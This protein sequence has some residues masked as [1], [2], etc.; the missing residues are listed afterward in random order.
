[1]RLIIRLL[2]LGSLLWVVPV[3]AGVTRWVSTTGSDSNTCVQAQ[4]QATA[5]LT[6]SAGITCMTPSNGD[7]LIITAGTYT[8]LRSV[9]DGGVTLPSGT[10]YANAATIR[11][12]TGDN[13]IL[14][15][16]SGWPMLH[17]A[18]VS[19]LILEDLIADGTNLTGTANP[20][21]VTAATD[22]I[23]FN[24]VTARNSLVTGF[25]ISGHF[26]ECN[27]CI[28]HHNGTHGST[29][30]GFYLS[31]ANNSA[32]NT[33]LRCIAY[34]N[35]GYGYHQASGSGGLG[36]TRSICDQ[37]SLHDNGTGGALMGD[38]QGGVQRGNVV[39]NTISYNNGTY[40][41]RIADASGGDSLLNSTAYGNGTGIAV[42]GDTI[43]ANIKNSLSVGN[44]G[45]NYTDTGLGGTTL[46]T[47]LFTGVATDLFVN[48][49]TF[50]FHLK[51]GSAALDAGTKIGLSFCGLAPDIGGFEFCLWSSVLSADRATDWTRAGAGTIPTRPTQCGSTVAAYS[52]TTNTI[53]T[54]LSSCAAGQHVKLGSG[55]FT[56]T[57]TITMHNDVTLRGAGS[58][59][60]ILNMSSPSNVC[61]G[62]PTA[63]A[64]C[65]G[66][67][68]SYY[69]NPDNEAFW[70]AGYSKGTTVITLD[71]NA[72][73]AV[74]D[75][76]ELNQLN[77]TTDDGGLYIINVGSS[78]CNITN[79]DRI[80][81]YRCQT[82]WTIVQAISGTGPYQVTID[83]PVIHPDI[84]SGRT[85]AA[86]WP[87][88]WKKNIGLEDM[89]INTASASGTSTNIT[90]WHCFYCW[91]K[92][93]NDTEAIGVGVDQCCGGRAH[94]FIGEAA[95][96]T[97]RDSY[98]YGTHSHGTRSYGVESDTGGF[99]LIENNIFEHIVTPI[100]PGTTSGDVYSYNYSIDDFCDQSVACSASTAMPGPTWSHDAGAMLNL[101]EGDQ[102][103]GILFDY[104]HGTTP[105]NT[106]FRSQFGPRDRGLS[107]NSQSV[108]LGAYGR[109]HNVLG[110]V[111]GEAGYHTS[112][113]QVNP[114]GT[115]CD[116][117]IYSMGWAGIGGCD[118]S[119]T[120]TVTTDTS[121]LSTSYRFGNY[122]VV[123][124]TVR[125]CGNSGNTGWVGTCGSTSEVPT[126]DSFY[127][128]SVPSSEILPNSF[129]LAAQPTVWWKTPWGTPHWPPIGPDVTGG[130][131]TSG[132]G[133]ESTLDGHAYKIPARLCYENTSKTSG[134]LNF[135]AGTCYLASSSS[136]GSLSGG[137][138]ISGTGSV[139]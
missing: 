138:R 74:G 21:S 89:R 60:T 115:N 54:A 84:V 31:G 28:A 80:T 27:D 36:P 39:K 64:I 102:G 35:S 6:I 13:V 137:V 85:P 41:F 106:V 112:Y 99:N 40:G 25:A 100:V 103:A 8:D 101:F 123:T 37:C 91:I 68:S 124:G 42:T 110:N 82:Q 118:N 20:V 131:V 15:T 97:V 3:E 57:G 52:G 109:Y 63:E 73:L 90:M 105:M 34:N 132:S 51:A 55:T 32:D 122:D 58:L 119:G 14:Q 129:Y 77:D 17:I 1:M 126:V 133:G 38:S 18:T 66:V 75:P 23:R 104:L 98:F 114:G 88:N 120:V 92:H 10:S 69:A 139:Q 48:P 65:M 70:T 43:N 12:N 67:S 50:D 47:N 83:P 127:P 86:W 96:N 111:F 135:D 45:A 7:V 107:I 9:F 11:A 81:G 19:Y 5:K 128:Q 53:N 136:S 94:V 46:V 24:R 72:N 29:D 116:S 117:T 87:T 30:H 134:I 78:L 61:N 121:V 79:G 130:N 16:T 108:Y 71:T 95:F 26:I 49:S 62:H 4:T 44:T 22:N 56:L 125:W 2:V 93:V 59:L 76:I 113:Q 33:C